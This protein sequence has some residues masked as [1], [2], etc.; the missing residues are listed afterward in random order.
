MTENIHTKQL[1][2]NGLARQAMVLGIPIPALAIC[3]M[4]GLLSALITMP[5]LHGSALFFLL[6]PLPPL[7]FIRSICMND[8][9]ALR[10]VLAEC[11][12]FIRRRNVR[13][14]NHTNTI[15]S[16]KY[17]RQLNDY[18]RFIEISTQKSDFGTRFHAED[19][20]TRY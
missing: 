2:F 11:K 6:M 1:T 8:D 4:G 17:G 5:F 19:L 13:L 15:L 7:A 12:W 3:G 9:Q 16:T 10:I 18:Q 14:F 20:P